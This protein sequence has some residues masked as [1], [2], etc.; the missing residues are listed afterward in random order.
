MLDSLVLG[1]L[2]LSAYA[3][4]LVVGRAVVFR[5]R[6]YRPMLLN[7]ALALAPG[8]VILVAGIVLLTGLPVPVRVLLVAVLA[9]IW[10][11]LLP[12]AGYLVTELNMSHR[13]EGE[14]VPMWFDIVLIVTLA[15]SGVASTLLSVFVGHLFYALT[16]YG[17]TADSLVRADSYLLVA[18]LLLLVAFGVFIGR[19]VRVNSWDVL[20]PWRLARTL[21]RGLRPQ[22]G[23][24]VAFTL[25]YAT[26]LGLMYLTVI[27]SVIHGLV[28]LEQ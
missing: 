6:L 18:V 15:M 2:G 21:V 24:A 25:L 8:V 1:V 12:N 16:R 20:R 7:I 19:H 23:A 14:T 17:D 26:F 3:A 9:L 4:L 13:R 28:L 10:L 27:G 5:T 22:L 11:L